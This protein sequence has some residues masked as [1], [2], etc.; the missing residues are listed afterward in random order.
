M[1]RTAAQQSVGQP[2]ETL[3]REQL[4]ELLKGGFAPKIILLRE[5]SY[6]KAGVNWVAFIFLPGYF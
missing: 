5:F 1:D 4:A 6:H 3:V 2:V